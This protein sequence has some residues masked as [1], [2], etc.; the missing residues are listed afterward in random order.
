MLKHRVINLAGSEHGVFCYHSK[1]K[2]LIFV[3]STFSYK[4]DIEIKRKIF[5]FF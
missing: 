3:I 4:V 1:I 2:R 5:L